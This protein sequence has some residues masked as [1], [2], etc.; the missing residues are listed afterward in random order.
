MIKSLYLLPFILNLF[1]F[2]SSAIAQSII[3][4]P[5]PLEANKAIEDILTGK[6]IPTGNGA[7][8]RDY[9]INL[10]EGDQIVIDLTSDEFDT[11]LILMAE[12]GSAIAEND[13]APG[14]TTNSLLFYRITKTGKYII[15]VTAFGATGNG[16]FRLKLTRLQPVN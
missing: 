12:D 4:T 7:F 5:I 13:D 9:I 1:L 10:Q 15:R 14:N 16:N 6:D 11:I 3:Y 2:C 8:A